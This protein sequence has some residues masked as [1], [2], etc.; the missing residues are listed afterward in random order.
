[1]SSEFKKFLFYLVWLTSV[2]LG[3]ITIFTNTPLAK[4]L[5]NELEILNLLQ[6]ITGLLA[7]TLLAF[8]LVLGSLMPKLIEKMGGWLFNFHLT[9]GLGA[10]GIML[11]HPTLFLFINYKIEGLT[12]AL[13]TFVPSFGS[14]QE[15]YYSFGKFALMLITIAVLAGHFRE[16]PALRKNWRKFHIL[17]YFA[18]VFV[19][20]HA[21]YSGTDAW[22]PPFAWFYWLAIGVVAIAVLSKL[23]GGFKK[24][25]KEE[26]GGAV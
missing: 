19:A 23:I 26:P 1:M 6:R 3:P 16:K 20:V 18:F 15:I 12:S 14:N 2:I 13:L 11:L 22:T 25:L 24:G 7:F 4:V 8:Q 9:E 17:N 10:W 5:D 21:Y